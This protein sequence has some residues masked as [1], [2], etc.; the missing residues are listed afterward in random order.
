MV[1]LIYAGVNGLLDN[2]PVLKITQW[3]TDFMS[4]MKSDQKEI[5][6][7]IEAKGSLS[8]ELEAKM[9]EVIQNFTKSYT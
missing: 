6:S 4:H 5:L 2:V 7:E 9:K 8:K 3:E 1:V